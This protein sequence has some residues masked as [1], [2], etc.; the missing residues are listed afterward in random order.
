MRNKYTKEFEDFVRKNVSKYTKEEFVL[1]LENKFNLKISVDIL[2]RYLNKHHI[3]ERYLDYKEY[4]KRDVLKYPIGT[5]KMTSEGIFVKVAQP[6]VW[7]RKAR[8]MYEKYHNCKLKEDEYI[9]FLNQDKNDCSKDNL[10]KSSRKEIAYLNVCKTFSKNPNL[11]KL[12]LLS[13]RLTIKANK[14]NR[15]N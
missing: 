12:G 10:I 8:I 11:T 7:R 1:L 5:E 14:I 3:K 6:D 2:R 4:N 9:V 13:A 15:E